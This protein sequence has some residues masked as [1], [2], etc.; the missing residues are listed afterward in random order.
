MNAV[1]MHKDI[2]VAAIECEDGQLVTLKEVLNPLHMPIGTY[3]DGLPM[4]YMA[5]YLQAWQASRQLPSD[6]E[7]VQLPFLQEGIAKS[8]GMSLT[9]S[10]WIRRST[11]ALCW[12]DVS[13]RKKGFTES[14]L[15]LTG[16]GEV[17]S[18][19]D[20]NTNG[21]LPKTWMIVD[22]ELTLIKAAPKW[23]PTTSANEVIASQLA[24]LCGVNHATYF[25]LK[26]D[27]KFYCASPCFINSENE[28]F[29]PISNYRHIIRT[30]GEGRLNRILS[31]DFI[32]TMTAFDL[33]IGNTDRHEGNFGCILNANDMSFVHPA[34][35]FDSGMCL[36][37]WYT[38][39]SCFKSI[40]KTRR[41]ALQNL[42]TI[43]FSIP[44]ED[45][46]R[47]VVEDVY[48]KFGFTKSV[49]KVSDEL[50]SNARQLQEKGGN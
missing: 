34:P 11:E 22:H 27:K 35:L 21:C 25:P 3:A 29:V 31:Q 45:T 12:D 39:N 5:V 32:N 24:Q 7:S 30:Q 2:E 14:L 47:S 6:R 44:C 40:F 48:K 46:L 28:D 17:V 10:Y 26:I 4:E 16:N 18:S 36:H 33:L 19:P 41:N 15:T 20:Y 8:R 43:P 49:Q 38:Q 37:Y 50:V 42:K 23:L 13:F 9:D 1:L